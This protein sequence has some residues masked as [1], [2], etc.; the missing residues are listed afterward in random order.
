[1]QRPVSQNTFCIQ[2]YPLFWLGFTRLSE[3]VTYKIPFKIT[4]FI[5]YLVPKPPFP[6]FCGSPRIVRYGILLKISSALFQK[7]HWSAFWVRYIAPFGKSTHSKWIFA[8][9][10]FPGTRVDMSM[11][12][13]R[14]SLYL[15]FY[16]VPKVIR[17]GLFRS[18]EILYWIK[19]SVW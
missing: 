2:L 17:K 12:S 7:H 4:F 11:H 5:V 16:H 13:F 15:K 19:I 8:C 3:R 14:S 9:Y 6:V 18:K 10:T 1:M